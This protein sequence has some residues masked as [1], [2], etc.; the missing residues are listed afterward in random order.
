MNLNQC[1]MGL[2]LMY[3]IVTA[4]KVTN[5]PIVTMVGDTGIG[6]STLMKGFM[7]YLIKEVEA[8]FYKELFLAQQ[9]VGDLIGIPDRA[10]DVTKW[11]A[12]EWWPGPNAK[13]VL[14]MDE[15]GDAPQD[16]R[17]AAMPM[18]LTRQMHQHVIPPGVM[19]VAAMN[20]LG[21]E[22]GGYTFTKQFKNRLMFWKV[23]P[24][25]EEWVSFAERKGYPA[26]IRAMIAEQPSFFDDQDASGS[27]WA[28]SEYYDGLPSRR[29]V[30]TAIELY[31]E[32]TDE[33]K[34][35]VGIDVL[36]SLVGTTVAANI[37]T[38][39][40]KEIKE[41][42]NAEDLFTKT[43]E[44]IKNISG[45]V[46]SG[47]IERLGAFNRL[48]KANIKAAGEK[49]LKRENSVKALAAYLIAI[50]EDMSVGTM[51]FI[52]KEV[53]GGTKILMQLTTEK[54]VYDRIISVL[55]GAKNGG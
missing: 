42:L 10:G 3:R 48:V 49:F 55:G 15:L 9:E 29:A 5:V 8:D 14:F 18:L 52:K 44:T 2:K 31:V 4:G 41:I 51:S 20:P 33:E 50:P 35:H 28:N 46:S 40:K 16:V 43:K 21:S 34:E 22:F 38:Y 54:G 37:L 32:M 7:K 11:L 19:L 39:S 6:K 23:K 53:G 26:Y 25:V 47:A 36:Q 17:R 45:W 27:T 13:G 30:S 12:P 1:F 24:T